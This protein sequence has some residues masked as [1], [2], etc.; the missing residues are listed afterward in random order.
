MTARFTLS[1][2]GDEI[3]EDVDEQ[4]AVLND[5]DIGYLELRSAWGTNVLELTDAQVGRLIEQCEAH[6]IAISC[7]GSPIGKSP[8]D[9]PIEKVVVDLER[10]LDIAVMVGTD[11]VRVFSFYPEADGLQAERVETSITRLQV[12]AEVAAERDVVLLL[13][14]EGGLVGDI[15]ERCHVLVEGVGSANLRY[16]WDTGNY[17][18]MG[19]ERSVE[20]GWPVL[21]EYTDCVQ[22]KD[23]RISDGTITVAGGGD[24]QV[25][26]LLENLRDCDYEGFLALE[27]H[28][29]IAGQRGGFSGAEGMKMAAEALRGLMAEVGCQEV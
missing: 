20:I 7:I 6:A 21:A 1:A 28:L 13:E 24:G 4:L 9:G 3:A 15:P 26:E 14:N 11:K 25:R 16:V 27:P 19:F 22:V 17:P 18:Q 2:F 5:L 10:V 8:I 23:C 29:L 12:L